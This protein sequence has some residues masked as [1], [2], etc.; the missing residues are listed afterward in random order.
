LADTQPARSVTRTPGRTGPQNAARSRW[1]TSSSASAVSSSKSGNEGVEVVRA[2]RTGRCPTPGAPRPA[3]P[4]PSRPGPRALPLLRGTSRPGPCGSSWRRGRTDCSTARHGKAGR[5]SSS[6]RPRPAKHGGDGT[7][8]TVAG[9]KRAVGHPVQTLPAFM[10]SRARDLPAPGCGARTMGG[11]QGCT[12]RPRVV[13]RQPG[14]ALLEVAHPPGGRPAGRC[15]SP[16]TEG[17]AS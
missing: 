1:P 14:R 8:L 7:G 5:R 15:A 9:T 4:D 3:G 13:D 17:L 16:P 10:G 6:A 12:S 2:P 11:V